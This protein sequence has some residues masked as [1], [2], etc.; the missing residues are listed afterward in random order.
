LLCDHTELGGVGHG[1]EHFGDMQPL[2]GRDASPDQTGPSRSLVIDEGHGEPEVLC[3]ESGGVTARPAADYDDVV[4]L[5]PLGGTAG[6]SLVVPAVT[7]PEPMQTRWL[8]IATAA[9][10]FVIVAAAAVWLFV[11]FT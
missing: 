7:L 1:G 4:Q 6:R 11:T 10:A 5:V 9:L 3:V 8:L 2:L